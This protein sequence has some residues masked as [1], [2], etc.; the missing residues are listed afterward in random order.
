MDLHFKI[1]QAHE[2]I[3]HLNVEIPQ[4]IT[5]MH[6]EDT[7]LLREEAQV[8]EY[9]SNLAHQIGLRHVTQARFNTIHM[10]RFRKIASMPGFTA[11][12]E[13]CASISIAAEVAQQDQPAGDAPALPLSVEDREYEEEEDAEWELQ[14]IYKAFTQ[15]AISELM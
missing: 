4:F 2:E 7:F 13:P 15:C 10:S 6:D 5:Y 1:L 9:D 14:G 11:I 12:L 8:H 3:K